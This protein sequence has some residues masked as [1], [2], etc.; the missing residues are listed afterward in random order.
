LRAGDRIA[1]LFL[2]RS[3]LSTGIFGPTREPG[4]LL[5]PVMAMDFIAMTGSYAVTPSRTDYTFKQSK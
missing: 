2:I 5:L 4:T 1:Q 3:L